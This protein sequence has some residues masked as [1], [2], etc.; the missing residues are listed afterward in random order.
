MV[1]AV[2]DTGIGIPAD[3]LPTVFD[4]FT[5]VEGSLSHSQGGLG[6]GLSLVKRLVE[7]HDGSVE[8]KSGGLGKGSTFSVRLPVL[9]AH[10]RP[11]G[12]GEKEAAAPKSSLR[13]LIVDDNQNN[14][15]SLG[16]MLRI[17]G[18]ETQTAYDGEEAVAA[19]MA[20]R[21]DVILL[22]IGLPKLN[23]YEACRRIREH[24][25]GDDVVL[26]AL[27]GWGRGRRSAVGRGGVRSPHGQAGEPGRPD[28]T[29]GRFAGGDGLNMFE[30][31]RWGTS[32]DTI[33]LRASCRECPRASPER[34]IDRFKAAQNMP[35]SMS[36]ARSVRAS[37]QLICGTRT[38]VRPTAVLSPGRSNQPLMGISSL[39]RSSEPTTRCGSSESLK[40][41]TERFHRDDGPTRE[42]GERSLA[43]RKLIGRFCDVLPIQWPTLT[44][45]ASSIAT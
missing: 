5:Q 42:A 28:E 21:P 18:N 2:K 17:M 31:F 27:T 8:A 15:D 25:W 38:V 32:G 13:I 22:D 26:I 36:D 44:D 4:L 16:M 9:I 7:M 40:E 11:H 43:F 3:K 14:A 20:F 30:S 12:S 33:N 39:G 41:S 45:A 10:S 23:G 37:S 24:L 1:V 29:T 19:A 6:I 35:S 34:T